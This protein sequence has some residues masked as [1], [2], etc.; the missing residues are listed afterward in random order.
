MQRNTQIM[1]VTFYVA[2][3]TYSVDLCENIALF[4]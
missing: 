2:L 3:F 4:G 1:R